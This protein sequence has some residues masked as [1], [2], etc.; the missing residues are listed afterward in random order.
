MAVI[1]VL[2]SE[3][4]I[5]HIDH[6]GATLRSS[7]QQVLDSRGIGHVTGTG[8][9]FQLHFTD[10]APRNR[11]DVLGGDLELLRLVLLA[12]CAA[13]VLWP[14]IHPGVLS[15]GHTD[16]DVEKVVHAVDDAL[17]MLIR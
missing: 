10:S 8:S 12:V 4:V 2:D 1:D 7:M 16:S 5:E 9:I 11:R 6:L 3:P 17:R 13:G 15:Y 14:P